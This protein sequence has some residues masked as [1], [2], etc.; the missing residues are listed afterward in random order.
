MAK[1]KKELKK[2]LKKATKRLKQYEADPALVGSPSEASWPFPRGFEKNNEPTFS[3][4]TPVTVDST[5]T[6]D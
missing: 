4:P 3:K 2:A 1:T 5:D 6:R